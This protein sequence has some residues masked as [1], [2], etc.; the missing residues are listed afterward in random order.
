MRQMRSWH[1]LFAVW[2]AIVAVSLAMEETVATETL[3][4][5]AGDPTDLPVLTKRGL[6]NI[7]VAKTANKDLQATNNKL[8]KMIS[9]PWETK[10]SKDCCKYNR[11]P[12][13]KFAF[14][15]RTY[16]KKS[17]GDCQSICNK[18][19]GCKSYSYNYKEKKC[20]YSSESLQYDQNWRFYSK[21]H[22][23]KGKATG[24]YNMF[25]G[26]KFIDPSME[27]R[28]GESAAE[29]KYSCTKDAGCGSFSYSP[30]L[31]KCATSGKQIGYGAGW[32]YY[33]KD[34]SNLVSPWKREQ[35]EENSEKAKL[36]KS[37]LTDIKHIRKREKTNAKK[38]LKLK[39]KLEKV[40][41]ESRRKSERNRKKDVK[42]AAMSAQVQNLIS[43][44]KNK[45]KRLKTRIASIVRKLD[46]AKIKNEKRVKKRLNA[47]GS[48]LKAKLSVQ[49]DITKKQLKALQTRYNHNK[50][51]ERGV[52]QRQKGDL[53]KLLAAHEKQKK[54]DTKMEAKEVAEK[55]A[56]SDS[57]NAEKE[58]EQKDTAKDLQKNTQNMKERL[59]DEKNAKNFLAS[60]EEQVASWYSKQKLET[61]E[62]RKKKYVERY[63][64]AKEA[65]TKA[66]EAERRAVKSEL[67][68]KDT[69]QKLKNSL[70]KRTKQEE[71]NKVTAKRNAEEKNHKAQLRE[72]MEK[73]TVKEGADNAKQKEGE[74]VIKMEQKAKKKKFDARTEAVA[75]A[76]VKRETA[77]EQQR[78]AIETKNKAEN[79][80]KKE[81]KIR[82][83]EHKGK[84]IHTK[85]R[86]KKAA[87]RK[88]LIFLEKKQKAEKARERA[89]KE[90]EK[91]SKER[92]KKVKDAAK[93]KI[94][95]AKKR[96]KERNR[97]VYKARSAAASKRARERASKAHERK[98]KS[99]MK[100]PYLRSAHSGWKDGSVTVPANSGAIMVGGGI[101]NHYRAWNRHSGFGES[102]PLG[103][104]WRCRMGFGKGKFSCFSLSYKLPRG[105][106]CI[107]QRVSSSRAGV[108]HASLPAGYTMVS[109]G[110]QNLYRTFNR[111]SAFEESLPSGNRWRCDTGFGAG[112]LNCYVRGCKFPHGGRCIT[113]SRTSY[114]AG[115]VWASCPRGYLVFGCG[116]NNRYRSWNPRA[117]F[118]DIRPIGNKCMGDM[119]FGPGRVTV[120]ARC[121][122]VSGGPA[123][124]QKPPPPPPSVRAPAG[125][126]SCIANS[127]WEMT[128]NYDCWGSTIRRYSRISLNS[129]AF[130]CTR[131]S[132]CLGFGF[133][134][135]QCQLRRTRKTSS[136]M[137]R[138][139]SGK[140]TPN[141]NYY[142]RLGRCQSAISKLMSAHRRRRRTLRRRRA[143]PHRRRSVGR[144]SRR[145]FTRRRRL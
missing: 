60:K 83:A 126:V 119:G 21:K 18:Y 145:R 56:M 47:G 131:T 74:R 78:I 33:E 70:E 110:V 142:S 11:I 93:K 41:Q 20:I 35:I 98:T 86:T 82:G 23:T 58:K 134:A 120:Y 128:K 96:E 90:A 46:E 13:F 84:E 121:C 75:K 79:K 91:M 112:R 44:Q 103:N 114:N 10:I 102:Y 49:I 68:E 63:E 76:N 137:R 106:H 53:R 40:A 3:G 42:Y 73:K 37:Y 54:Q 29:C 118:E 136:P 52:K 4:L 94:E 77:L 69:V 89:E 30:T 141:S 104:S 50:I 116:M 108:V 1:V 19:M 85:E 111:K 15:G 129:C 62:Q 64:E 61:D 122:K 31:L 138:C 107:N 22:T 45:S 109:G 80:E 123:A 135:R 36:K 55:K 65:Q 88:R 95:L 59:A 6:S 2:I 105:T 8:R 16:M 117:G 24:K 130:R 115:W 124:I 100:R 5:E 92:Q 57:A 72:Q 39:A 97:K 51:H 101:I 139:S 87:K 12:W 144:R 9:V 34:L 125:S 7:D 14:M 143:L 140:T 81:A 133:S 17:R 113:R 132:G 32:Q 28:K 38:E 71:T 26:M 127:K 25:P 66:M 99:E 67:R 48:E 43:R 27:I